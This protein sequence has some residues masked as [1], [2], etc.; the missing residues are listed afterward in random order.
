MKRVGSRYPARCRKRG[1]AI[2]TNAMEAS[3][4]LNAYGTADA[5]LGNFANLDVRMARQVYIALKRFTANLCN[6]EATKND[7]GILTVSDNVNLPKMALNADY[8]ETALSK[9]ETVWNNTVDAYKVSLNVA[10]DAPGDFLPYLPWF[11]GYDIMQIRAMKPKLDE[12]TKIAYIKLSELMRSLP[13]RQE[14][15]KFGR[16]EDYY[17]DFKEGVYGGGKEAW[18]YNKRI[19]TPYDPTDPLFHFTPE[20]SRIEV[21]GSSASTYGDYDVMRILNIQ[22]QGEQ[23]DKYK[24]GPFVG[25]GWGRRASQLIPSGAF[26]AVGADPRT[27]SPGARPTL[28]GGRMRRTVYPSRRRM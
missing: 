2:P 8:D 12:R 17:R 5:S 26:L 15:T 22:P 16:W 28:A 27:W 23:A 9:I 11:V 10:Q 1:G 24:E 7:N 25:T 21:K 4:D 19:S 6:P 18:L 13:P 3:Y 20:R 14:P